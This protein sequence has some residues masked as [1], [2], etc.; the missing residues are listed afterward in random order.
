MKITR[1]S[2]KH[3]CGARPILAGQGDLASARCE[4]LAGL[5]GDRLY[6]ATS[7][8]VDWSHLNIPAPFAPAFAA[9]PPVYW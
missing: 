2:S 1:R 7:N 6:I 4:T 8:G 9:A 5:F 3:P